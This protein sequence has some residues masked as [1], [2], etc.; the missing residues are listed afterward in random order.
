MN[1]IGPRAMVWDTPL[2][3]SWMEMVPASVCTAPSPTKI[4]PATKAIGNT[5]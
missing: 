5:M 3:A 4:N 2:M 1:P